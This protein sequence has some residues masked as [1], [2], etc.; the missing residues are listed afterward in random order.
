MVEMG[1]SAFSRVLV[2][3]QSRLSP[4]DI[5]KFHLTTYEDLKVFITELQKEQAQRRG[6]RN[7]NKIRP[8]LNG[9][10]QYG[11]VIEVF[12]NAKPD[13]LAFVWVRLIQM[14]KCKQKPTNISVGAD[15]IMSPSKSSNLS[16]TIFRR[17]FNLQIFR[18]PQN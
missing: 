9:L 18:L 17:L 13:I 12:V 3:F 8:F 6:F 14:N 10:E 5:I 1:E 7:L 15:Q 11:K 16:H 4:Q 2:A